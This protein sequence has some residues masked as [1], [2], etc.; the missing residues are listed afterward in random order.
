MSFETLP[1]ELLIQ[2]ADCLEQ[3]DINSLVRLN[4]RCHQTLL[5]YLY[6]FNIQYREF[7]AIR[8]LAEHG[9]EHV[10]HWVLQSIPHMPRSVRKEWSHVLSVFK[11][12]SGPPNQP[13]RAPLFIA[14]KRNDI[15]MVKLLLDMGFDPN[16]SS[17]Y[18]YPALA[19]AAES[20]STEMAQA[21]LDHDSSANCPASTWDAALAAAI[22]HGHEQILSNILTALRRWNP[23]DAP[24]R[25]R[26]ALECAIMHDQ[27]WAVRLLLEDVGIHS[28]LRSD[29]S[30][31]DVAIVCGRSRMARFLLDA[32]ASPHQAT[33]R[34]RLTPLIR[35]A[36]IANAELV[37]ML[38]DA[39]ANPDQPDAAK[40]TALGCAAERGDLT[41]ARLLLY[42]HADASIM[43]DAGETPL[44]IGARTGNER[45]VR[46]LLDYG[47]DPNTADGN[48]C[49]PLFHAAGRGD[50]T[51]AGFLL[52]YG[53]DATMT[54]NVVE[55]ALLPAVRRGNRD[56]ARML[57]DA[58]AP[59]DPVDILGRT[60]LSYAA[61]RGD[62]PMMRL[63]A[64]FNVDF[65]TRDI[66]TG[67]TPVQWAEAT[68]K[69]NALAIIQLMFVVGGDRN[70]LGV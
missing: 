49:T 47:V 31:L 55:T 40:R 18:L 7:S 24:E 21:I 35:A 23:C 65:G 39:G 37:K 44:A 57:L 66:L 43:N 11:G 27:L 41:I 12:T 30:P 8:H 59:P 1:D 54:N 53:A 22:A 29:M 34:D 38:L 60:P 69:I 51:M 56:V 48:G 67:R 19:V 6:G 26:E 63:L 4:R 68:L 13:T 46:I 33:G 70:C 17:Y 14:L 28:S 16:A 20:G 15:G 10:L 64:A 61:E 25:S 50:P 36:R 32:G 5:L 45:I 52:R 62:L 58:G 42:H 2:I 9:Y 3:H